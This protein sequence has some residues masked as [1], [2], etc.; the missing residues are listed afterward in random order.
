MFAGQ[1]KSREDVCHAGVDISLLRQ[2]NLKMQNKN[3]CI[4]IYEHM[5][6]SADNAT[7]P[8]CELIVKQPDQNNKYT[9]DIFNYEENNNFCSA[10]R[11]LLYKV[12]LTIITHPPKTTVM[13]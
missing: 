9:I 6:S 8:Q 13:F 12:L 7:Y 1:T 2:S 5:G 3:D 11:T 4:F 10:L